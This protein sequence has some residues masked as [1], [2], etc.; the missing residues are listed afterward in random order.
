[1]RGWGSY[2]WASEGQ[3]KLGMALGHQHGLMWQSRPQVSMAFGGNMD[4]KHQYRLPDAV[5]SRTQT[6]SSVAAQAR[7]SHGLRWWHRP[8]ISACSLLLFHLQFHL[9]P[10]RLNCSASL[11]SPITHLLIVVVVFIGPAVSSCLSPV[12]PALLGS[13]RGLWPLAS[14]RLSY[15]Y[16]YVW[17][18]W[19]ITICNS[20]GNVHS[21]TSFR[22]SPD[23]RGFHFYHGAERMVVWFT[24]TLQSLTV[25]FEYRVKM[26]RSSVPPQDR[27]RQLRL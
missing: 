17:F 5:R 14:S 15:Y 6:W 7:V 16:L 4:H 3:D 11:F 22:T 9:S 21:N 18:R 23:Q 13:G 27:R 10:Q 25:T 1:M 19:K 26:T 20:R 2:P 24:H 8:P 12:W